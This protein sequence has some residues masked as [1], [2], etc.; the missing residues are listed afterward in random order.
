MIASAANAAPANPGGYHL[1]VGVTQ[2]NTSSTQLPYFEYF[3]KMR[4]HESDFM[5][6]VSGGGRRNFYA[7][8][9]CGGSETA[10]Q[11][12]SATMTFDEL[13]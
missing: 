9:T 3:K 11:D 6:K 2:P 4:R 13:R 1:R 7:E 12:Q 10:Q 5:T 8:A